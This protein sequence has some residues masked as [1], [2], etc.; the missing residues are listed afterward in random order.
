MLT[1]PSKT[2]RLALFA[3][4]SIAGIAAVAAPGDVALAKDKG[5]E[6]PI[7][8]TVD[9]TV[10]QFKSIEIDGVKIAYREAGDPRKPTI[11]LL[12]G[13]PTSSHMF[14]ELMPI[15]AEKYHVLAPDYPGFGASDMPPME[16]F[17]YSFANLAS[18]MNEFVA[19]KG[20]DSFTLYAMDY[21]APIGYRLFDMAP[22]RVAGLI[23]QNGNAYEE[24][25][26][27]FWEP[28]KA[29][30]AEPTPANAKPLRAFLEF[31]AQVW[32]YT[33]GVPDEAIALV[34]PDNWHH[35]QFLLD[36][37]GA[38][39]IQIELFKSYGTNVPEYAKWQAKFREFQPPA[40]I[41]WGKNDHIFPPEGAFPY[42]RD[43][44][45]VELH[46]L[47][48]GHFVLE[49]H[50]EYVAEEIMDF[51]KREVSS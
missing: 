24:G 30:W 23:I 11:L 27:D 17:E 44:D 33:H 18:V 42:E 31:D 13:F 38:K 39:D 29:Y 32:Q 14:R 36:R 47:N 8:A 51:M 21:G 2:R 9:A 25:L 50:L 10:T 7:Q 1:S 49:T 48:A 4:A 19:A 12:H 46:L 5:A 15:L 37:P 34:S 35:D 26:K 22:E 3:A 6:A 45:D 28:F 43:L 40:L 16:D 20:V 41:V